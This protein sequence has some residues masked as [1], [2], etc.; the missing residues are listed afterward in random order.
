[1][2]LARGNQLM[3]QQRFTKAIATVGQALARLYKHETRRD[4]VQAL[5]LCGNAYERLGLLWAARGTYLSGASIAAN[6]FWTYNTV[7]RGFVACANHLKWVE[8]RLGRMPHLLA[9]HELDIMLRSGEGVDVPETVIDNDA[10]FDGLTARLILRIP[11]ELHSELSAL[12][13]TLDQLGLYTSASSALFLLGHPERMEELVVD[14]TGSDKVAEK[15]WQ[16]QADIPLPHRPNLY[17][18]RRTSLSTKI[19]GCRIVADCSVDYPCI[20]FVETIFSILESM[21]STSTLE[22]AFAMEPEVT[23]S[24]D[25]GEPIDGF[26]SVEEQER[27]GRSHFIVRCLATNPYELVGENGAR[28][29]DEAF[30]ESLNILPHIVQF[31]DFERDLETLFRDE[32]VIERASVFAGGIGFVRNVLGAAPKFRLKDWMDPDT[33]SAMV[34]VEPWRPEAGATMSE[35]PTSAPLRMGKGEAPPGQ[36]DYERLSHDQMIVMSP[37][38]HRLWDRAK[39]S[40]VVFVSF[41]DGSNPPV[42]G[43]VFKERVAAFE[44]FQAWQSEFGEADEEKILRIAIVLTCPRYFSPVAELDSG[45]F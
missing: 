2:L 41:P 3:D 16:I 28:F 19:L 38:R 4:I 25:I 17:E 45:V 43:I 6:D 23:M 11:P 35:T 30:M 42:L 20:E 39:W 12:P 13:H 37:I 8:L 9:W 1:L 33:S 40:A 18:G 15:I 24:I 7:S 26:F 31:E 5:F 34:R 14:E 10:M 27:L 36:F 44:I 29:R 21:L 22:R 32:R